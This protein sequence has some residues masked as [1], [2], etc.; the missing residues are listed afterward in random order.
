M[1]QL[2]EIAFP[3]TGGHWREYVGTRNVQQRNSSNSRN[4]NKYE[5]PRWTFSIATKRNSIRETGSALDRDN[6]KLRFS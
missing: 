5:A 2:G 3:N 6:N 1:S 4:M